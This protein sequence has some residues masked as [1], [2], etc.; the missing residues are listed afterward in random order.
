MQGKMVKGTYSAES[1][2]NMELRVPSGTINRLE[3]G[4]AKIYMYG[5]ILSTVYLFIYPLLFL[6]FF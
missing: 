6:L 3:L 2:I 5:Y 1:V 4:T